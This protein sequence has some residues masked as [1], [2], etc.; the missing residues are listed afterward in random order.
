[1]IV[2]WRKEGRNEKLL[3]KKQYSKV[4]DQKDQEDVAKSQQIN[5]KSSLNS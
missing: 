1:V 4:V 5:W 2:G 3:C